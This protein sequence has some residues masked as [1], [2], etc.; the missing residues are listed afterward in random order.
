MVP[1]VSTGT[2]LHAIW[3]GLENDGNSFVYQNVLGDSESAGEWEF[4]VEYCC[5]P[6]F[7]HTPIAVSPGDTITSTMSYSGS[8]WS[9]SYSISGS[10]SASGSFTDA[11]VSDYGTIDKAVLAVELLSGG[12]WDFGEIQWSN[13]Q[14]TAT[15][16]SVAWCGQ[17]FTTS[18]SFT[19]QVSGTSNSL[20]GSSATCSYSSIIFKAP[21]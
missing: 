19:Y 16:T 21:T 14:I 9:S 20:S 11:A 2:G 13:L 1:A 4:W 7:K 15:T 12:S 17:S 3:P 10:T 18:G 6:D 5:D 8:Q